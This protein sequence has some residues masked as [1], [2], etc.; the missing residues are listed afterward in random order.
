VHILTGFLGSGKTSLL[1]RALASRFGPETAVIVNEFGDIAL[2]QIFIESASD[3]V[4]VMKSGC[5]CCSI[6]TDLVGALMSLAGMAA[7]G[8]SAFRRIVIETSGISD[9]IPILMTLRSDFNLLTRFHI[10]SIICTVD[11]TAR[12]DVRSRRE[13]L[14]Q[15]AAADLCIVT[16]TDLSDA[17]A[18]G[19]TQGWVH[20][21]NPIAAV[22]LGTSNDFV[23]WFERERPD[24]IERL[25]VSD[26]LP[27]RTNISH[28]IRSIVLRPEEPQCWP[29]F[30]TWLSALIHLHGDRL[31]RVKGVLRDGERQAW[32]G[33]H[34][35][36]R[37][38][39]PPQH[40]DSARTPD[41]SYMVFI[42]ENLDC[43]LIEKSYRR[44][45]TASRF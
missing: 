17:E 9:P 37:F 24:L 27:A 13:V 36:G 2:D 10:G 14:T 20:S 3:E 23:S 18:A 26:P 5:V 29:R 30:A 21:V 4:V 19:E 40:I 31:L 16:K 15:V 34:G 43:R 33:V 6:R 1:N 11:A 45:M 35:V 22:A 41:N 12:E 44:W 38:L 8:A 39:Y 28:N 7:S 32:I 42:T 25:A